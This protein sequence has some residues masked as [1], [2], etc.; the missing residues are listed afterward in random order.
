MN[1]AT[2]TQIE[3]EAKEY[4]ES[5][6]MQEQVY[7]TSKAMFEEYAKQDFIAGATK[8]AELLEQEKAKGEK[9]ADALKSLLLI[10][11]HPKSEIYEDAKKA[12]T[13]YK[14]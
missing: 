11:G 9:L 1:Q 7:P 12:L 10:C 8:Y 14:K 3:N 2:K 4:A 5:L 6:N 13:E